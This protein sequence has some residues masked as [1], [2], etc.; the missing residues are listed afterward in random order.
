MSVVLGCLVGREPRVKTQAEASAIALAHAEAREQ[1]L[2]TEVCGYS[3]DQD[4]RVWVRAGN[5]DSWKLDE[6]VVFISLLC[7]GNDDWL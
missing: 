7:N 1:K 5:D 4:G 3:W 2:V 6:D